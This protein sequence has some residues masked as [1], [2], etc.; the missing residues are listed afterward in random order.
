M[1]DGDWKREPGTHPSREV[2]AL[3]AAAQTGERGVLHF[4]A[5]TDRL[6]GEQEHEFGGRDR[7]QVE[8]RL[9]GLRAARDELFVWLA[10]ATRTVA[11]DGG[12]F[13]GTGRR[14]CG[15]P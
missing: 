1:R 6:M 8:R 7:R 4:V 3:I 13:G 12:G 5:R 2:G 9:E 14:G 15:G 11:G 10:T